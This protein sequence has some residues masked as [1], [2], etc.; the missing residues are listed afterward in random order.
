MFP[1]ITLGPNDCRI[2]LSNT[3]YLQDGC[4]QNRTRLLTNL[5]LSQVEGVPGIEQ[6]GGRRAAGEVAM[7]RV[8]QLPEIKQEGGKSTKSFF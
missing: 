3:C 1:Y 4:T 7:V 5:R 8:L 2:N 6:S